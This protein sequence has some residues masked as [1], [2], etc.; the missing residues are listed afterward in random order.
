M[1]QND[2]QIIPAKTSDYKLVS[3]FINSCPYYFRHL[4]WHLPVDWLGTQPYYL[5]QYQNK[6]IALIICPYMNEKQ[7]WL[8]CFA[9]QAISSASVAWKHLLDQCKAELSA[10]GTDHLYSISLQDWYQDLLLSSGFCQDNQ[11]VVLEIQLSTNPISVLPVEGYTLSRMQPFELGNVW[12]L[13]KLCFH[14]L[15]QMSHEDILTA[16]QVS[17]NCSTVKT[18]NGQLVGYQISNSLPTGGHLARIAVHPLF[19]GKGISKLLLTDLLEIFR[20]TGTY[21]V[22]VNTQ[23]DNL[24][25]ITLYKKFG[26]V[27][28]G[29]HYPVYLLKI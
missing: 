1:F 26:F 10:K 7:A 3:D 17:E 25:A 2:F 29:E 14:P 4:D 19:Q 11:I 23:A 6:T 21:R 16:F 24:R 13:D 12:E 9:G 15:W 8:R 18:L 20:Q 27:Q 5:C 22:T 28:T